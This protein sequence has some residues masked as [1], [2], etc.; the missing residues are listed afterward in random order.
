MCPAAR[1]DPITNV[2]GIAGAYRTPLIAAEVYGVFTNTIPTAP[3]RGAGRPDATYVIERLIDV[4]AAETGID[5]IELR[6]RNLIP[7]EA[8]PFQT[9]LVFQYD[10]GDFRANLDAAAARADVAGFPSRKA[11]SAKR[12]KLRGLGICN[13]VEAAGGPYGNPQPDQARILV[14]EDGTAHLYTGAM[15][16]GQGLETAFAQMAAVKFDIPIDR[17]VYHQGNTDDLPSGRG[18]GGSSGLCVSGSAV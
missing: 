2:G 8:M 5:P 9:G 4:A 1:Q 14:R 12:G 6:R 10:C 17:L 3:Y 18:S 7:A 13:P 15:S 11:E 16:V